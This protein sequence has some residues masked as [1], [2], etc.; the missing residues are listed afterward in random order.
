MLKQQ[1]GKDAHSLSRREL[2]EKTDNT[3]ISAQPISLAFHKAL[4]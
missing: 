4:T 3:L 2:D 1:F